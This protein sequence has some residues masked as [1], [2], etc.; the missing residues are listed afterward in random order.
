MVQV[1]SRSWRR[2]LE[3]QHNSLFRSALKSFLHLAFHRVF[4]RRPPDSDVTAFQLQ[5]T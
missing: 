5:V 1:L 4:L 3:L 2:V